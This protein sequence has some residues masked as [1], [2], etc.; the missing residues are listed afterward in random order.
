MELINRALEFEQEKRKSL[1]TSDR[2]NLQ[3]KQR[4]RHHGYH[5]TSNGNKA[6]N[7]KTFKR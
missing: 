3:G 7:R 2:V 5:E 6:K 1:S 4:P